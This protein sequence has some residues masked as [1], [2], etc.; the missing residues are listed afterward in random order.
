MR[1]NAR[2]WSQLMNG[3]GGGRG[4][5]PGYGP[6]YGGGNPM[7][8]KD[9]IGMMGP[10]GMMGGYPQAA[11]GQTMDS[12]AEAQAA[13]NAAAAQARALAAYGG[14][15]AGPVAPGPMGYNPIGPASDAQPSYPVGLDFNWARGGAAFPFLPPPIPLPGWI[16]WGLPILPPPCFPTKV[17]PDVIPVNVGR[18]RAGETKVVSVT[19]AGC[20][21]FKLK[22][23][24]IPSDVAGCICIDSIVIRRCEQLGTGGT[25]EG[26][27]SGRF[28][29][30]LA[31]CCYALACDIAYPSDIIKVTI[32]N[33]SKADIDHPCLLA[34][35][36]ELLQ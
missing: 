2:E 26:S 20:S 11:F 34:L 3:G 13:A 10:P 18:L 22:T 33:F 19:I 14:Y 35:V 28:F 24:S 23:L 27:L 17:C 6:G 12:T 1:G 4:Q 32:T 30:E 25:G 16:D 31:A 29:S 8:Q 5:A 9:A 7:Q 21:W 36:G 15:P